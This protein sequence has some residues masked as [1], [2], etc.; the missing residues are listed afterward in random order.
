M[1]SYRCAIGRTQYLSKL[2]SLY[3]R[4]HSRNGALLQ[5]TTRKQSLMEGQSIDYTLTYII[6]GQSIK[7]VC[8]WYVSTQQLTNKLYSST[9][10]LLLYNIMINSSRTSCYAL[11]HV[12]MIQLIPY[13]TVVLSVQLLQFE[14]T[15]EFVEKLKISLYSKMYD[16]Y[17]EMLSIS[18]EI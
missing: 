12:L 9:S 1:R 2:T 17:T 15:S 16:N 5:L 7:H 10:N 14:F 3:R 11:R 4:L 6:Y 18:S 13:M 8:C